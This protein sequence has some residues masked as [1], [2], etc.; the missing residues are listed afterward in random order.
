M[1]PPFMS[2]KKTVGLIVEH[3]QPDGNIQE[4]HSTDD[5]EHAHIAA[6]EDILRAIKDNDPRHLALAL[7]A[8][9]EIFDSEPHVEGPHEN[10]EG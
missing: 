5:E 6:A 4:S 9:F 7:K 1:I 10:E 3:R 2:K 8:A